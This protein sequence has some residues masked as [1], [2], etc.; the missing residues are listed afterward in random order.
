MNER[1]APDDANSEPELAERRA[2]AHLSTL[3]LLSLRGDELV[4]R[5]PQTSQQRGAQ[6]L[7]LLD[8]LCNPDRNV[9]ARWLA[10]GLCDLLAELDG[11]RLDRSC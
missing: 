9:R 6:S 1:A 11:R 7:A 5:A 3:Y 2:R 4:A 10:H 8:G